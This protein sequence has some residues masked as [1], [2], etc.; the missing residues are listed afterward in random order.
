MNKPTR[1]TES[2]ATLMDHLYCTNATNKITSWGILIFEISDH[3]STFCS[4]SLS[5]VSNPPKNLI[6]E[7]KNCDKEIFLNHFNDLAIKINNSITSCYEN[8]EVNEIM[9]MF[10]NNLVQIFNWHAPIKAQ[11]RI[12]FYLSKKPWISTDILKSIQT[13]K[14][15]VQKMLQKE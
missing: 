10:L 15:Y 9:D 13:Q 4:L 7:M 8:L 3:M 11:T 2:S 1:I 14:C 12:K 6:W 5:P